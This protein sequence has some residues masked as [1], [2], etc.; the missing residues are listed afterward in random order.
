[1]SVL[2]QE[3]MFVSG[4]KSVLHGDTEG[5]NETHPVR[6]PGEDLP[7][8]DTTAG[9]GHSWRYERARKCVCGGEFSHSSS[10]EQNHVKT[11]Y[12]NPL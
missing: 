3:I 6:P 12:L 8:T 4:A 1:M 11:S 7:P 2:K 9:G 5:E 10:S